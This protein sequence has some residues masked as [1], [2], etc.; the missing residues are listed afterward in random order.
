MRTG[1]QFTKR[2]TSEQQLYA[3]KRKLEVHDHERWQDALS[4]LR[5]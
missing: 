1:P 4:D 3:E 5:A 2:A